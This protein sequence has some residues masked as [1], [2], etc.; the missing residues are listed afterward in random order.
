MIKVP[1]FNAIK[2]NSDQTPTDKIAVITPKGRYSDSAVVETKEAGLENW[3][4]LEAL[5]WV[6]DKGQGT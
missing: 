5:D 4:D 6:E 1:L 3:I 2:E